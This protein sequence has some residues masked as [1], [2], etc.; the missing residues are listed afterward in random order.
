MNTSTTGPRHYNPDWLDDDALVAGFVARQSEFAF[1][2]DELARAPRVGSVQHHLLVGPRGS[3]KTTL[4]KRLAVA[5]RRDEDLRDH[6]VALSFPEELYQV[7]HLAD[8]WWAAGEAL[9]DEL[10][11]LGQQ[12]AAE[13]LYA[14]VDDYRAGAAADARSDGISDA[15]LARLQA[16]CGELGRRPVLLVDN[17]DLVFQ[18]IDKSGRRLKDPHAA[19]YWALRE[20]LSTTTAPIVIGGSIRL[21]EPFTDYD[22]AF[23]DFFLPKRLGK[24]PRA[25]VFRVLETLAEQQ[26]VPQVKERLLTRPSRIDALYE[27][28]G[29]NPRA[30]GL[31]FELLREGPTSR[32]VEDFERLMDITTPYYK[33]RFEDLAEQAQVVMH[34]LAVRRPSGDGLRFGHTAAEIGAHAGLATNTVSAQLDVLEREGLVE[35]NAAHGRTQYRIAEQLFRLWLQMRATRRIRQSVTGLSEF[36]EAMFDLDELKACL[37][38]ESGAGPL[39]AAWLSFAVASGG[40]AASL[41]RG[42]EARGADY[43]LEQ[44][45][46]DGSQFD[47]YL[48]AGDLSAELDAIVRLRQRL[49]DCRGGGL[50]SAEQDALIGSLDLTL[51][52]KQASVEALCDP[53]RAPEEVARL[54]GLLAAERR[55]LRSRGLGDDDLARLFRLRAKGYLPL[56]WLTVGDAEAALLE[57][58]RATIAALIW[59]LLGAREWAK[60]ADD[61]EARNWLEWGKREAHAATSTEWANIAGAMRRSGRP[62]PAAEALDQAFQMGE[63]ARAWYERGALLDAGKG[64]AAEAEAAYRRAIELDPADAWPWN[65]LGFL[66]KNKL[67]RFNEAEAAYRRA[68]ELDPAFAWAW[69]NL[70]FLLADQLKRFDEAEAAYRRTIEL[71]P[72][73]AWP[74]NNLGLLLADQLKRFDEAEA[75]YRRA[76]ELDP[77]DAWP[78]NNLGVLL[79]DPLNRFDEAEVAFRRAID[80]DPAT[81]VAD[82]ARMNL[83][84]LLE[85]QNRPDEA[86]EVYARASER[87]TRFRSSFQQRAARL[88]DRALVES[89]RRAW[90]ANDPTALREALRRLRA[91]SADLAGTLVDE[92][93]VEGVLAPALTCGTAARDLLKLLRELGFEPSARPLLLA[94]EAAIT[95]RPQSLDELEPEVQ[96]AAKRMFQRL[97][98]DG[99]PP[100]ELGIG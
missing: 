14:A 92:A 9:A 74:W 99:K 30:L 73:F 64:D 36:L 50:T 94:F 51:A 42:L 23:Y 38:R 46:A 10:D 52:A 59:R 1:L 55:R 48:P 41:R 44:V 24:L 67:Q 6:L 15:G 79:A 61:A 91:E 57:P 17:L 8:F 47:D 27:L 39:A 72:A 22:K 90:R 63:S 13:R 76:I 88:K 77:A 3:G 95:N 16:A 54:R 82:W 71:D 100:A 49:S 87:N 7:K 25:E 31:I 37:S 84:Q 98:G 80:L 70:G 40:H 69:N 68:I 62:A 93:F 53:A 11:R 18:R 81:E 45:H 43:V 60:F 78:W 20:A 83:G 33:A 96:G 5:I 21:S 19:A 4:L 29:G 12:A 75:A 28:T 66:L 97:T 32:A 86:I 56:P 58:D 85:Q 26:G 89:A 34:A 35:K 65:S 2:R